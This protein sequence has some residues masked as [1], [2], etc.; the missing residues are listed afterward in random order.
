MRAYK[1]DPQPEVGVV[2]GQ[3]IVA[4]DCEEQPP[5]EAIVDY[6]G[7]CPSDTLPCDIHG[8]CAV[9]TIPYTGDTVRTVSFVF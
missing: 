3:I 7:S 1:V 6:R 5:R 4:I 2:D 8:H 9:V